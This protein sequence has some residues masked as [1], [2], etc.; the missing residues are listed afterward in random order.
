MD[1]II[2]EIFHM[3]LFILHS[4]SIIFIII[5][6]MILFRVSFYYE[7][8]IHTLLI[9]MKLFL[10]SLSNS[11]HR[12]KDCIQIKG[13]YLNR[14]INVWDKYSKVYSHI[15]QHLLVKSF[16]TSI[17][18]NMNNFQ[19]LSLSQNIWTYIPY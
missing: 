16:L 19:G 7:I 17:I 8:A 5:S 2:F 11:T 6:I 12:V 18:D 3:H 4:I 15:W 9:T 1:A 10:L 13:S 14:I